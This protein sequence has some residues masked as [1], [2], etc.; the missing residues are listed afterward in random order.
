M[1]DYESK[2]PPSDDVAVDE[3]FH[4]TISAPLPEGTL[5]P[6]YEAKTRVLNTA[7]RYP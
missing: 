1:G 7:V 4:D 5:D 6:V 2:R 3:I